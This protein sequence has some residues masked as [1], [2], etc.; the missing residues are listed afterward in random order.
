LRSRCLFKIISLHLS[1]I[2]YY[3]VLL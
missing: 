1:K 2:S 3:W